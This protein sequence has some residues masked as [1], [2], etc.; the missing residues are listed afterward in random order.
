M[1]ISFA[2]LIFYCFKPNLGGGGQTASGESQESAEQCIKTQKG[3]VLTTCSPSLQIESMTSPISIL[4]LGSKTVL[5]MS[6]K[7]IFQG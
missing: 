6:Y 4:V 7:W 3:V 2:R 1:Q 5:F